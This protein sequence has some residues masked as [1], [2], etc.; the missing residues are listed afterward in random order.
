MP[1]P[2]QSN[3]MQIYKHEYTR[4][5]QITQSCYVISQL[6]H[7]VK[8]S[9]LGLMIKH[10]QF[11]LNHST[12]HIF[13]QKYIL[14]HCFGNSKTLGYYSRK[15]HNST[16]HLVNPKS[17]AIPGPMY[18]KKTLTHDFIISNPNQPVTAPSRPLFAQ[19]VSINS[20]NV[21]PSFGTN[22]MAIQGL[23]LTNT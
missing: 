3:H 22:Q 5:I 8:I 1:V 18:T 16:V 15:N 13:S 19:L 10:E 6:I 7:H 9:S 14:E 21:V 12:T 17:T 23:K 2:I 20:N 4:I 11:N